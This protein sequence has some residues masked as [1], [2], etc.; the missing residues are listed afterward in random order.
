MPRFA[1]LRH[2]PGP[3]STRALHWDLMFECGNVLRTFACPD[4]PTVGQP[5]PVERL[6]DHRL[7]YLDY[8]GPVS[9]GRG[10]VSKW[11]CGEFSVIAETP[12]QWLLD[13]CGRRWT[14]HVRFDAGDG[15]RWTVTRADFD[16]RADS[17]PD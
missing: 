14:G 1:I 4:E 9:R 13:V 10:V 3:S 5:L 8:E 16:T 7:E 11:D 12:Q 15:H 17:T 6:D 2:Q